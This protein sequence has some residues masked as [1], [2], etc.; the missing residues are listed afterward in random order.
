MYQNPSGSF[1]VKRVEAPTD[2]APGQTANILAGGFVLGE[3]VDFQVTNL[4][5]GHVYSGCP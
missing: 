2:Y 5:N 1:R 3:T 4:T